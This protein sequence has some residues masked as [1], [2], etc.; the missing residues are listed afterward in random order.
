MVGEALQVYSYEPASEPRLTNPAEVQDAIRGLKVSKAPG[1]N[2]IPNR[3]LKHLPQRAVSLFAAIFN[4]ALLAQYFPSVRKHARIVSILKPGKDPALHSS[5]RPICLLETIGTLF[6]NML[7]SRILSEVSGRGLL[8]DEQF[9]FRPKHST[10]LQL[11]RLVE[12]VTRN[13]GEKRLT[14][15]VILDVAKA[16]DTISVNGLLFKLTALNFTFYLV[17]STSSYLHNRTF[18]ASFHTATSN[19]RDLRAGIAKEGIMSPILF[20]LYVNDMPVPSRHYELALYADDTAIIATFRNPKLLVSYFEAYLSDLEG[21]LSV[22][23]IAINVSKSNAKAG[24]QFPKPRPVQLLGEPIQWVDSARYLGV[25][26][27]D[28][29]ASHRPGQEESCPTNGSA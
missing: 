18:E 8:R 11:A 12:R 27:D 20:S 6:E 28:L 10:T 9:R 25:N 5:Y 29:V 24:W 2:G 19:R 4:A 14:C 15:A 26:L 13:F 23:R 22:R 7:L 21:W 1:P 17:K 3:A 16:L